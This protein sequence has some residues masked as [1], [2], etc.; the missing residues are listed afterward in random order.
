MRKAQILAA[1]A[2]AVMITGCGSMTAPSSSSGQSSPHQTTASSG[3][4]ATTVGVRMAS[5]IG[6]VLVDSKG[7]TLY[8]DD[9]EKS[10]KVLCAKSDCTAI[11]MPL[12]L[13]GSKAPTGPSSVSSMLSTT[14]RPDGKIQVTLKGSP[15]YTFAYDMAAG[16]TKGDG[17]RDSFD[18]TAFS[19][20]AAT[21][22]GAAATSSPTS[23]GNGG[24]YG[25]Y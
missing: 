3:T 8:L 11:W 17:Q 13:T 25:G 16:Q 10:G 9:Q 20:H 21:P 24:G 12:I 18:G 23:T 19:W 2:C 1:A 5:G 15:L 6:N 14:K 7:R 4:K 22:A